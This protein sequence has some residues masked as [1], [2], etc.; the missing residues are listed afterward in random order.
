M[1]V[2][3]ALGHSALASADLPALEARIRRI[4]R[5]LAPVAAMHALVVTHCAGTRGWLAHAAL[6]ADLQAAQSAGLVGHLLARELRNELPGLPVTSLL[7]QAVVHGEADA[8]PDEVPPCRIVELPL[9]RQLAERDDLV[10][11]VGAVPV[12][13]D[14]DA[15]LVPSDA[16]LDHDQVAA[17]LAIEL[18]ADILLLLADV[19][20]VYA[21]WPAAQDRIEAFDPHQPI[22]GALDAATMGGKLRAAC[23]FAR[24]PGTFAA[25]G[26]A[27]AADALV[28]ER[29][30]TCVRM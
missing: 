26:A 8:G 20:A 27:G 3:A 7:A 25:I 16:R 23:R 15:L 18:R 21:R 9:L 19:D 13:L 5:A 4:A 17:S 2:V 6:P 29:A 12:Q 14:A 10:L 22:P 30:G 11:C 28:A 24:T 1:L